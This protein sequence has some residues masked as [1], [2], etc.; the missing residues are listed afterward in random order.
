MNR[1]SL[2]TAEKIE[3]M[4]GIVRRTLAY[5]DAAMLCH[6]DAEKGAVVPLHHHEPVQI[7]IC[8]KGRIRFYYDEPGGETFEVTAG[9]GYVVPANRPHGADVL[10]DSAY[11]EVFAP[12]REDYKDF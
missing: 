5:N 1:K 2:D 9:D 8:L 11:V 4:Q 3:A 6:F 7:G 12:M 10:E